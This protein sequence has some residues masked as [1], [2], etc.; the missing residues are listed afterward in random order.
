M[1]LAYHAATGRSFLSGH[2]QIVTSI[3]FR[4]NGSLKIEDRSKKEG[5]FQFKMKSTVFPMPHSG[6][7]CQANLSNW[8]WKWRDRSPL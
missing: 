1:A 3:Y 7:N 6:I 5:S 2:L 4:G 8:F